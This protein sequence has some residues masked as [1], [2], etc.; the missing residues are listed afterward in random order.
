MGKAAPSPGIQP[1]ANG[2]RGEPGFRPIAA[3]Q[4]KDGRNFFKKYEREYD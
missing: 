3:V 4:P 2:R 1:A